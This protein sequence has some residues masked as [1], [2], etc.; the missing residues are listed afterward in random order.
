MEIYARI[1]ITLKIIVCIGTK[2]DAFFI[3]KK[4]N[5]CFINRKQKYSL[6]EKQYSVSVKI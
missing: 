1:R 5:K 3:N 2:L 4:L 6:I